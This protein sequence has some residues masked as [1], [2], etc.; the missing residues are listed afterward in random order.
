MADG[1]S[2]A[3]RIAGRAFSE[4]L[5][6]CP[7]EGAIFSPTGVEELGVGYAKRHEDQTGG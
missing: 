6:Y 2:Y 7:T 5:L 1:K 4:I 3:A